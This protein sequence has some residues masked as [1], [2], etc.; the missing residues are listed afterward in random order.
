[1]KVIEI[2]NCNNELVRNFI[3]ALDSQGKPCMYDTVTQ[4]SFYNQGT[5]EFIA[6]PKN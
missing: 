2:Y 3:P 1:M 4:Q 6:G 5:G